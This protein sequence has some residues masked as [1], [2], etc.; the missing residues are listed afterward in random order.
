[1]TRL[2]ALDKMLAFINPETESGRDAALMCGATADL[3]PDDFPFNGDDLVLTTPLD[4][5]N[6][7]FDAAFRIFSALLPGWAIYQMTSWPDH[8]AK[9]EIWG[10]HEAR[11]GKRWHDARDGRFD[12]DAPNLGHA[13]LLA[14]FKAYR[15]RVVAELLKA[16]AKAGGAA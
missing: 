13:L 2:E 5:V 1:M 11:D 12:A 16:E 7:S 4:A 10:T 8:P 14:T 9:A 3:Y 6:G 15:E